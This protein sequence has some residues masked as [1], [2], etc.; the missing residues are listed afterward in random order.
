MHPAMIGPGQSS[1]APPDATAPRLASDAARPR[2]PF[3]TTRARSRG[4]T[5]AAGLALVL[6]LGV[7]AFKL[8][9]LPVTAAPIVRGTAVDAVYATGTIE[10][11]DRVVVKAR[12]AGPVEL[13]VREGAHVKRG[14]LLAAIDDPTLKHDLDRGRA[15]AWAATRQAGKNGP[16]LAM[17]RAQARALEAELNTARSERGRVANLVASGSSPQAELDRLTDTSAALEARL[18]A[19][20]AQQD[21][22]GIDLAARALGSSAA[23][24]SLAARLLDSEV[25]SPI[26]GVVL[27]RFVEPGEVAMVNSPIVKVGTTDDLILECAIDEA[28]IG[29]VTV[30]KKVAVSLYA[31]HEAVYE[32]Q[33][34]EILP[35]ADRGKKTFLT[36]VRLEHPPA[37]LRSGM[38]AEANVLID[39]RQGAVLAPADA[40]DASGAALVV[41]GGR[42]QRRV[43]RIGVRD[44]LRVEVVEGVAEGDEVVVGAPEALRALTDGTRVKATS[45]PAA[46]VGARPA[47]ARAGMTL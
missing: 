8:R 23:V 33:I 1:D 31:F 25:R 14:D 41:A 27:A 5:I 12:A 32:G 15:E 30:G 2:A 38:T 16:Q 45:R 44:M 19:N 43:L 40:I 35:D 28:D 21:A 13:K 22:M 10:P 39:E 7:V 29:R 36:K 20:L 37:G 34:F 11:F 4:W 3:Q 42:V 18:A 46:A 24:D 17:L 47:V 9:P 26:D 6:A